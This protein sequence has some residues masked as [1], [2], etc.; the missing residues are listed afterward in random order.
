MPTLSALTI[1]A[2]KLN[3]QEIYAES[4]SD[5]DDTTPAT[6]E[7][8][9]GGLDADNLSGD[10]P[11][12][13]CQPGAF[14]R[15]IQIPFERWEFIYAKQHGTVTDSGTRVSE[16]SVV[17]ASLSTRFFLPWDVTA[18]YVS[19]QALWRPDASGVL[20]TT[21]VPQEWSQEAWD[22]RFYINGTEVAG[23]RL[24]MT[25]TR[26][27]TQAVVSSAVNWDT[28]LGYAEE[29][30]WMWYAH[31]A[32]IGS[33]STD[34][35]GSRSKGYHTVHCKVRLDL[36]DVESPSNYSDAKIAKL[37]IPSGALSIIAVR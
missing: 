26:W 11:A 1:N 29:S 6:L 23:G 9:N 19:W 21:P 20:A 30:R 12:W 37:I 10:I 17:V 16:N 4:I 25:P 36:S 32:A 33:N 5:P 28:G 18:L 2:T 35:S 24:T 27:D 15:A 7:V 31:A 22:A 8:L 13:A 14:F 3:I 34:F